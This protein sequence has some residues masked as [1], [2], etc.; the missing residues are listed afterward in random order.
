[1]DVHKS[2]LRNAAVVAKLN[3]Y[4]Q[5]PEG[6]EIMTKFFAS[7]DG[8]DLRAAENALCVPVEEIVNH[9][10]EMDLVQGF[11]STVIYN[12]EL[13][14]FI[15]SQGISKRRLHNN[16]RLKRMGAHPVKLWVADKTIALLEW[17]DVIIL[18]MICFV[19]L[20]F[21]F[22]AFDAEVQNLLTDLTW[23]VRANI[24]C[25]LVIFFYKLLLAW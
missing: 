8:I 20:W 4:F 18:V 3:D 12:I 16:I 25:R 24:Y 9:L 17:S 15:N 13:L 21:L 22:Y 14:N 7:E 6:V 23:I 2:Q 11:A 10:N 1:M 19:A 5:T